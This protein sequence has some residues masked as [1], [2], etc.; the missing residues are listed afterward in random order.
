MNFVDVKYVGLLSSRLS[1]FKKKTNE[2]Y[3]FR[4]PLCGDSEKNQYKARGYL[5]PSK[6]RMSF[7]YKCHNCGDTRSLAN[8]IKFI[9]HALYQNYL[10]EGFKKDVQGETKGQEK[11]KK[12]V[13]G[14]DFLERKLGAVRLDR[15]PNNNS[16]YRFIKER[17]IPDA[18]HERLYVIYDEKNLERIDKKYKGRIHG[19]DSRLIL[20]FCDRSGRLVGIAARATNASSSLRYLAFKIEE[21]APMIFGLDY[22]KRNAREPIYV[23]EGPIDS[24]FLPNAIA[25]GGA[26]FS[27]LDQE[28]RKDKCVIVFDN[29][30]RNPE[31]VKRMKKI[32]AAGYKIC[33]W[34]ETIKEK[35]INDM[36]LEG[37]DSVEIVNL[38]NKNTFSGLQ[39]T[40]SLNEWKRCDV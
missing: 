32:I 8:L 6:D 16:V 40:A 38:I 34:P 35:D 15:I 1:H 13:R 29:E 21:D 39:A 9:D 28:V 4:C 18:V 19:N 26:D 23:V 5:Y 31:I 7:V 11:K 3:N 36:I 14:S 30:P 37:K 20:P 10:L 17:K 2:L 12:T 27:K 33:I 25:V 24:L 22:L